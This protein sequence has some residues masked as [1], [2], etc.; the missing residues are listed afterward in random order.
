[1]ED[2]WKAVPTVNIR[3]IFVVENGTLETHLHC[4]FTY[5]Q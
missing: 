2:K 4:P 1:L 3:L 5:Y